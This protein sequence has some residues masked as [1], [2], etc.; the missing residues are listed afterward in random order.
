MV[1]LSRLKSAV[2]EY[3]LM[4]TD[5]LKFMVF[6]FK[7]KIKRYIFTY[8]VKYLFEIECNI[9]VLVEANLILN[10]VYTYKKLDIETWMDISQKLNPLHCTKYF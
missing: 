2:N 1:K 5:G 7:G 10:T 3:L 4:C 8:I 9:C 6:Y